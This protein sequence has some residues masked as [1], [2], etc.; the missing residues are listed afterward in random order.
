MATYKKIQDWVKRE[1]G[2]VPKSC[3]I[4][5]VKEQAGLPVRKAH[6]RK[7]DERVYPCPTEKSKAIQAALLHFKV[8]E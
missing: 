3:W 1:Y 2:F 5:D 8:L 4:A 7:S 6:N